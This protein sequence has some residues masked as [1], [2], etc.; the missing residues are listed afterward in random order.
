MQLRQIVLDQVKAGMSQK[1]F[2]NNPDAEV[3]KFKEMDNDEVL[4]LI[5]EALD[6]LLL[7]IKRR[8]R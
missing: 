8:D 5:S 6:E 2:Q 4:Y 3:E 7:N 1:D